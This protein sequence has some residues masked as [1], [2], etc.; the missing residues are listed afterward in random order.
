M[1]LDKLGEPNPSR[2][3]ILKCQEEVNAEIKVELLW[4]PSKE[5]HLQQDAVPDEDLW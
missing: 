2:K 1:E 3:F 5:P 4:V